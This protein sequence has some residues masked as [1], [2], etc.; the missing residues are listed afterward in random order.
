MTTV[1]DIAQAAGV[2]HSTVA[3]AL[4][5]D[6][7]LSE[8]TRK[9]LR[10]LADR[11]G[12]RENPFLSSWMAQRHG[13]TKRRFSVP[14]GYLVGYKNM[15][16]WENSP[17]V[18][19]YFCGARD[20]A[21]ELGCELEPFW[22]W[23]K[24]MTA[25]RMSNILRYRG[26]RGVLIGSFQ[27]AHAHLALPWEHFTA[28]AQAY[29]LVR[30]NFSRTANNYMGTMKEVLRQLRKKGY[31]RIGHVVT[32]AVDARVRYQWS[33]T[34][35]HYQQ[36]IASDQRIPN[37]VLEKLD[38]D[39]IGRW[40]KK[41]KP[42]AVISPHTELP[43]YFLQKGICMPEELGYATT[44]WQEN[45]YGLSGVDQCVE[46]AGA[47]AMDLLIQKIMLNETGLDADPRVVL[48]EGRWVE[49]RTLRSGKRAAS[50]VHLPR[51]TY[52]D[53]APTLK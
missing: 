20:R 24:G 15:S 36:Q 33:S 53:R 25:R 38:W 19:R 1:R 29:S 50:L 42:G 51:E 2:H 26:I 48:T 23:E 7:R 21:R 49:G 28:V 32:G 35:L 10:H 41:H 18:Y 43:E 4:K 45:P 3:R 22:L 40:L 46:K 39:R 31:H 37:L 27:V 16:L 44:D 11:M 17:G 14:L 12:Y 9:G 6:P 52:L 30:P 5:N 8:S 34:F 13:R 47:A